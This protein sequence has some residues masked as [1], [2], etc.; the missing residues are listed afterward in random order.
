VAELVARRGQHNRRRPKTV[1][2]HRHAQQGGECHFGHA[3]INIDVMWVLF[4]SV[5]DGI[6]IVVVRQMQKSTTFISIV[7]GNSKVGNSNIFKIHISGK[8]WKLLLRGV[9]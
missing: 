7:L 8:V 1:G 9:I 2:T 3:D 5:W 4:F 6:L